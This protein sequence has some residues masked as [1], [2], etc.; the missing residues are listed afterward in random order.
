MSDGGSPIPEP[1]VHDA[2]ARRGSRRKP[3]PRHCN[4]KGFPRCI[5]SGSSILKQI[6]A[7]SNARL[8][9]IHPLLLEMDARARAKREAEGE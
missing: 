6:L 2:P 9:D 3:L 8:R 4:E 1:K 5:H 7:V